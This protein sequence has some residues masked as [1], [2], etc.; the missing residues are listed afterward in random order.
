MIQIENISKSY[1][2][3]LLFENISFKIN[4]RERLGLVGRNGH[5]KTTLFKLI[6][7][8]EI[9]DSG[10]IIIPKNYKIGYVTQ[11]LDFTEKNIIEEGL[12]GLGQN[13]HDQI[14]KV[15]KILYG[16]GFSKKDMQANPNKFSG[17]FQVRLNLAKVILSEPDLLLLDEPTNYLDIL[18]I[19]WMERFLLSWPHELILITH[20]RSFMDKV[21]THAIGIH[22]KKIRKIKGNTEKY[23]TQIALDE[24]IYEKTRINSEKR[25]KEIKQ[26]INR[27]RAKARLASMVQSRIKTI[28]KITQNEKLEQIT[29]LDFCFKNKPLNAKNLLTATDIYFSY[30]SAKPVIK[31]F[32]LNIKQKDRI[33][34]IG[35]NGKGKTTLIKLLAR[36]LEPQKGKIVS[37]QK[38][39]KGFF[40]QTNIYNLVDRNTVEEEILLS[41]PGTERQA[42]RNICGALMFEGDDAL[43]KISVLSGGEK[44][45][46]MLGKI[47]VKP[48]NLLLLD[49]PTNH[50]DMESCDALLA[51]IDSFNGAVVMVTHNE[52]FIQAIAERL[53]VFQNENIS[54]F[55]GSYQ[56]FMEKIGWESEEAGSKKKRDN[57]S[58]NSMQVKCN[59]K[60]LRK[61]RAAI[62]IR[63]SKAVGP[64][65]K[66]ILSIEENIEFYENKL[67]CLNKEMIEVSNACNGLKIKQV[68]QSICNCQ[69]T[70][71]IF[72]TK[73]E[74]YTSEI[75]QREEN[76]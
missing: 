37:H 66:Q 67:H 12:K 7:K 38:L 40:E 18:S 32:N 28:N 68:S 62:N 16:L 53:I 55:E 69:Q 49:E 31:G 2:G 33:C 22:R 76:L 54:V 74:K 42:A 5:G 51:A 71:D 30:D 58:V 52:L 43:K 11:H 64:L 41:S 35:K 59:R 61:K 10:K 9:A 20:N 60:D 34:I 47:L 36:A 8:N 29:T 56:N 13:K 75:E 27:F 26:F 70:I 50:L 72:Y 17:G 45:R 73:L 15:E 24:E 6:V 48:I 23:Y 3:Q 14:W 63:R 25:Q 21:I 57:S 39:E 46:V 19:R 4:P 44:S 65:K 1:G